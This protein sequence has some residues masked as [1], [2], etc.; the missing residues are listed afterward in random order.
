MMTDLAS[1]D[2]MSILEIVGALRATRRRED[3][4]RLV[5]PKLGRLVGSD[6]T[7]YNEVNPVAGEVTGFI[8]PD[9][10]NMA[11]LL[12]SLQRFMRDHPVIMHHL[13]TG[14]GQAL[15]ISDF[16]SQRELHDTGLYQELYRPMGVEFQISLTLPTRKPLIAALVFNRKQSDFS[17]RD[18]TVLNT[19]RPHLT[20]AFDVA[21]FT[22]RL[23][24]RLERQSGILENLPDGVVVLNGRSRIDL[25]TQKARMWLG[26]YFPG[27]ARAAG[28]L[29][30]E[31]AAWLR[32]QISAGDDLSAPTPVFH[33]AL[34]E[35]ILQVRLID[36]ADM[37][38]MLVMAE[39]QQEKS[40][41]PLESLGLTPRQAETLLHLSQGCGNEEIAQRLRISVRTVHKH[42]ESIFKILNVNSRTAA[43]HLAHSRLR[44]ILMTLLLMACGFMDILVQYC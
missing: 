31:L 41:K 8:D 40:A 34:G 36:S 3:L 16:I 20:A 38:R 23:K 4:A 10:F 2:L 37:G 33:K 28:A 15:R 1:N 19:L 13:A 25:W 30:D 27:S 42:I 9:E 14:D 7:A 29:P 22:A 18:R 39:I 32:Q 6:I 44:M 26:K 12:A 21:R 35:D 11:M 17:E 24:K 5:I 43:S